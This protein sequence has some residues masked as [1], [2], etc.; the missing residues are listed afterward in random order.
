[1]YPAKNSKQELL[2]NNTKQPKISPERS[3]DQGEQT[4][5]E[6]SGKIKTFTWK[7]QGG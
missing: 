1:L 2:A 7:A 4:H 3:S 6:K 5:R